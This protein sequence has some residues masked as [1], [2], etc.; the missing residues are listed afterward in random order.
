MADISAFA[1]Q[2]A[3]VRE[4]NKGAN[5]ARYQSAL[6]EAREYATRFL[7]LNPSRAPALFYRVHHMGGGRY[8]VQACYT[9]NQGTN[10]SVARW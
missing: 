10:Y 4:P 3:P 2:I 9:S 7:A 1:N 5:R 6:D 8:C